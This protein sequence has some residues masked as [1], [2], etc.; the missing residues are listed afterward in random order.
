MA[1][2]S[3]DKIPFETRL[4]WVTS[5]SEFFLGPCPPEQ[6]A[7]VR[8]I[9]L[10]LKSNGSIESLAETATTQS[11]DN[12]RLREYPARYQIPKAILAGIDSAEKKVKRTELFA[13]GCILYQLI[14]GK[15]IFADLGDDDKSEE[16]LQRRYVQGLF[17]DDLW[18]LHKSVRILICWCPEF[19]EQLAEFRAME[20]RGNGKRPL[21]PQTP[22]S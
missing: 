4:K 17:P 19:A 5:I 14:S 8:D 3:L 9:D 7:D 21:L 11:P 16:E 15:A 2:D 6:P 13:L 10:V 1:A 18:G 12:V 22:P 20:S